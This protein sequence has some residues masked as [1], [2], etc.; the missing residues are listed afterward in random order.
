VS[1]LSLYH[2]IVIIRTLLKNPQYSRLIAKKLPQPGLAF[3][4]AKILTVLS[5]TELTAEIFAARTWG[6]RGRWSVV[7][8]IETIR[9]GATS[10]RSNSSI[11]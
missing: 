1:L 3:S 5:Y 2:D 7:L 8:M 10:P 11:L 4:I 6:S 9:Y